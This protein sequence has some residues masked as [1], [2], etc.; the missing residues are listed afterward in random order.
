[1]ASGT[2]HLATITAAESAL[3]SAGAYSV[4][5]YVSKSGARYTVFRGR[6]TVEADPAQGTSAVGR[7]HPRKALEAIEAVLEKRASREEMS[8]SIQFGGTNRQLSLCSP[9]DLIKM[10][11]YYLSEVRKEEQAERI[12]QGLGTGRRILTRF[13]R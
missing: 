8:Y 13:V 10:R 4:T 12:A 5:G 1:V 11:N 7:S 3:Y 9:A 6:I 2:D